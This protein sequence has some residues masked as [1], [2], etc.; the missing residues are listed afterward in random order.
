MTEDLSN[1]ENVLV[2][3]FSEDSNAYEAMTVL[4]ELDSQHQ[5]H[6]EG[7]A[8]VLRDEDGHV[9]VKDEADDESYGGTFG[10]GLVGLLIGIIGGP[11]GILIGGATGVLIGSLFDANDADDTESDLAD[12][13]K[14]VRVGRTAVLADVTEPSTDVIDDAMSRLG[15]E[16]LR[17][18]VE[19]VEAEIAA[20]EQAQRKAKR[21]ARKQLLEARHNKHKEEIRGKIE[22]LKARLQ[23]HTKAEATAP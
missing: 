21:E 19:D 17:R 10:G 2:V 3:T 22:E 11:I 5:V 4:K 20:I 13:S 1:N 7:V 12:V 16:V 6:L 8:V 9:V 14:S 23:G 18:S 15:G